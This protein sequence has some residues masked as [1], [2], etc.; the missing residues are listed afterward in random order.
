VSDGT[1]AR[2]A[3]KPLLEAQPV[4]ATA[5]VASRTPRLT[6]KRAFF[7]IPLLLRLCTEA[8]A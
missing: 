1:L 3:D 8:Q 7:N 2:I 4:L 5:I 6:N